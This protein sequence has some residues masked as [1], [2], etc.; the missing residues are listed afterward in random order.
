MV[1]EIFGS[2]RH[3]GVKNVKQYYLNIQFLIFDH[4]IYMIIE[5][6]YVHKI[7]VVI[8]IL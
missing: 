3:L 1:K 2:L 8:Y 4:L 6:C 5:C 7:N